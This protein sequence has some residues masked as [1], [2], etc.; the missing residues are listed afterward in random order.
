[1]SNANRFSPRYRANRSGSKQPK[2]PDKKS[3][4]ASPLG[5]KVQSACSIGTPPSFS[6][7]EPFSKS[8]V[9]IKVPR[10]N[11]G[12]PDISVPE[13]KG[14]SDLVMI[15]PSIEDKV[16]NISPLETKVKQIKKGKK[17]SGRVDSSPT[18]QTL[19][20]DDLKEGEG[21]S[22]YLDSVPGGPTEGGVS[23]PYLLTIE[24]VEGR[25]LDPYLAVSSDLKMT[26]V[27]ECKLDGG[28]GETKDDVIGEDESKDS[29]SATET[30]SVETKS[31]DDECSPLQ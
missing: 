31:E 29:G 4:R 17:V 12:K 18:D 8:V 27:S 11:E 20:R 24:S 3:N 1:M 14:G 9:T 26:E 25:V 23:S 2:V 28:S 15:E 19:V 6:E 22:S 21:E 16:V 7:E 5:A 30:S 13:C 10:P